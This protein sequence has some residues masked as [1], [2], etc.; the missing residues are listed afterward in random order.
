VCGCA[1]VGSDDKWRVVAAAVVV[2]V[3]VVKT[4]ARRHHRCLQR[5]KHVCRKRNTKATAHAATRQ[6]KP[7]TIA[8]CPGTTHQ[9]L[10]RHQTEAQTPRHPRRQLRHPH[11]A[12]AH[13]HCFYRRRRV[14]HRRLPQRRR[15]PRHRC[16]WTIEMTCASF[17]IHLRTSLPSLRALRQTK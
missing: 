6:H 3:V 8:S 14:S 11:L 10:L 13:N 16:T 15:R 2:A 5:R 9:H 17:L 12:C 1:V 7:E 4:G